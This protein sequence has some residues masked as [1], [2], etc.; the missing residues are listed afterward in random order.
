MARPFDEDSGVLFLQE[1]AP[2]YTSSGAPQPPA[3][4]AS[5]FWTSQVPVAAPPYAQAPTWS[6]GQWSPPLQPVQPPHYTPRPI[7]LG[8][9]PRRRWGLRFMMFFGVLGL[10]AFLF[11]D[12]LPPF[13]RSL[14]QAS[15][16]WDSLTASI[17][18]AAGG[19]TGK[20]TAA[21]TESAP[22][23]PAAPRGPQ[24]VPMPSPNSAPPPPL[25]AAHPHPAVAAAAPEPAPRARAAAPSPHPVRVAS[26][27]HPAGARK[28]ND[29]F[30][31]DDAAAAALNKPLKTLSTV[32]A[33]QTAPA[34]R[35]TVAARQTAPAPRET[36][37]AEPPARAERPAREPK[38]AP[39]SLEDLM[40]STLKHP[41]KGNREIDRRLAGM[42]E[43]RDGEAPRKKAEVEAP[44]THALSRVEIQ[45]AMNGLKDQMHQCYQQFQQQGPADV[46][47]T[48]SESG[49]VTAVALSGQFSGT[50]TGACVE[51]AVKGVSFPASSGLRFDY[52]LSLR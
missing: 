36:A 24:I 29:P 21:K 44:T 26:A 1:L 32:A 37:P 25:P 15:A 6:E 8:M 11:R 39:G 14:S 35:E 19:L 50:P 48:V 49:K 52:R 27:S 23:T 20:S 17:R 40:S 51:K 18:R 22:A 30:E 31:N 3:E 45:T 4:P 34:P 46:K 13:P 2:R 7:G 16:T 10:G 28:S 38:A 9:R 43:S 47:V 42:N 33:R 41:A 5:P 12:R